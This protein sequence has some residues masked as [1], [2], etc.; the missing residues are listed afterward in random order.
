MVY[1]EDYIRSIWNDPG[2]ISEMV[3]ASDAYKI[4]TRLNDLD[5]KFFVFE[6]NYLELKTFINHWTHS[7]NMHILFHQ[8]EM[9]KRLII[10]RQVIRMFHNF[11]SSASMLVEH[12]RK[13]IRKHY[14][15]TDFL[16]DYFKE[17]KLRFSGNAD[18]KFIEDI[19]NYTLHYGLPISG[20]TVNL[21]FSDQP[22]H[23][24][25]FYMEKTRLISADW[26]WNK[27]KDFLINAEE[28]IDVGDLS[29][30]YFQQILDFHSWMHSSLQT[31]HEVE[32]TWLDK[33][34]QRCDDLLG[35]Q[36]GNP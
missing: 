10:I 3:Y 22:E 26:K 2:A 31:L 12:T 14:E 17:V 20:V 24:A 15:G 25:F 6:Q 13:L 33:M 18:S 11:V 36:Q 28:K 30:S 29:D 27:G 32:L 16:Y 4:Y 21:D 34:G 9:Q 35:R 19:R 23:T 7:D 5:I 1:T 8:Q